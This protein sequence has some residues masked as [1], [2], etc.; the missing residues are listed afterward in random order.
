[1]DEQ[2]LI[3]RLAVSPIS[4][5][6]TRRGE[7]VFLS[8]RASRYWAIGSAAGVVM[9]VHTGVSV[10]SATIHCGCGGVTAM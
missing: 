7:I 8:C 3:R 5:R 9:D 4:P 1:M 6:R 2:H 10:G